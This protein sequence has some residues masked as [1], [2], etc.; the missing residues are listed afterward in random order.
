MACFPCQ[1][2]ISQQNDE[3]KGAKTIFSRNNRKIILDLAMTLVSLGAL[4]SFT[5]STALVTRPEIFNIVAS[6]FFLIYWLTRLM[7]DLFTALDKRRNP[8]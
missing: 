8:P 7:T 3:G 1:S 5:F 2:L 4:I 6:F